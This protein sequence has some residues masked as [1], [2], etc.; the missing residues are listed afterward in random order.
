MERISKMELLNSAT[1][2]LST[3]QAASF[4]FMVKR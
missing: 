3:Y 4:D 1:S 2:L